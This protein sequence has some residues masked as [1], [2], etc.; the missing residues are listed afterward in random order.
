MIYQP[1]DIVIWNGWMAEFQHY[2][3]SQTR[4]VITLITGS[5]K[6]VSLRNLSYYR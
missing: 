6:T 5:T 1:G 4:A 3:R 2:T